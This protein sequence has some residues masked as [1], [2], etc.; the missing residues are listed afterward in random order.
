M[1]KLSLLASGALWA[2]LPSIAVLTSCGEK[3]D[4][5][6][7]PVV[8]EPEAEVTSFTATVSYQFSELS[9]TDMAYGSFGM[10][11]AMD[12]GNAQDAF[13]SW[14]GGNNKPDC[15]IARN[16]KKQT[17]GGVA[18]TVNGLT[19]ETAY[20][21][22]M[23]FKSEDGEVRKISATKHFTT[24]KFAPEFV[25]NAPE[26]VLYFGAD[27]SGSVQAPVA[28]LAVCTTGVAFSEDA[29][30]IVVDDKAATC[31]LANDGTFALTVK[32]LKPNTTYYCR[33]YAQ[34]NGADE[35]YYGNVAS[36]TTKDIDEM[37]VDLGL[38]VYW[39]SC[40]FMAQEPCEPGETFS[41]GALVSAHSGTLEKYPY[42]QAIQDSTFFLGDDISG[43]EY[44]VVHMT[45]GGKWRMPTYAEV[46]E[47]GEKCNIRIVDPYYSEA[48]YDE[49]FEYT[50]YNYYAEFRGNG[51]MIKLSMH[52]PYYYSNKF[53]NS[54][55]RWTGSSPKQY[56]I[57]Q[58][59][60]E[61]YIDF[62]KDN[63][64]DCAVTFWSNTDYYT[65]EPEVGMSIYNVY[66]EYPIRPVRDKD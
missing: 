22:C 27:L 14:L 3:E 55:Y 66:E 42:R 9:L 44:D 52:V 8:V 29:Q 40:D 15:Q 59:G 48:I 21:C 2:I 53:Y 62:Y 25:T 6:V 13:D 60:E 12:N 38:S 34:V 30:N 16:V 57:D 46:K 35:V 5:P 63:Y 4:G 47:L 11:Y 1:K 54:N 64:F 37:A 51:N 17:G 7:A 24:V 32:G 43:T 49:D 28:D 19:P 56:I 39:A 26:N 33:P 61:E 31:V 58:V 23:Y 10:L 36:F 18:V 20:V 45:Y 50:S 41:W 65:D